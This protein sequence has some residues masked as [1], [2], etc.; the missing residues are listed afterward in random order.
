M[1]TSSATVRGKTILE[2]YSFCD[3]LI[4]KRDLTSFADDNAFDYFGLIQSNR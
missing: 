2:K 1:E 4:N 3:E